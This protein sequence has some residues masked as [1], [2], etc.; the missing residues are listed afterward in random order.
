MTL[1]QTLV[2]RDHILQISDRRLTTSAGSVFDDSYNKAVSWCGEFAVGFTGIAFINAAQTKP[3]SEWL[4]EALVDKS[5]IHE[6]VESVRS[7]L[8]RAMRRLPGYWPDLRL[9]IVLAGF[10]FSS[11]SDPTARTPLAFRISNFESEGRVYRRHQQGFVAESLMHPGDRSFIYLTAGALMSLDDT[12]LLRRRLTKL[13]RE[14]AWNHIIRLLVTMQR[15][16]A[17]RDS[18]VGCDAMVVSI[19]RDKSLSGGILTDMGSMDI[20]TENSM[21]TFMSA[22]G[23]THKRMGPHFVC[24]GTALA[25]VE[26]EVIGDSPADQRLRVRIL[27]L[28]T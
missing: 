21:F 18:T 9:S 13:T 11:D 20:T 1:I 22:G 12:R 27:K 15:Q 24:G 8:E 25:D 23:L 10:G 6:A 16:V 28:A 19:P 26:G 7:G 14:M 2:T 17:K 3:V 5:D 4:A